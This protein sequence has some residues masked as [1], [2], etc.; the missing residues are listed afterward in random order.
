MRKFL[1]YFS[2]GTWILLAVAILLLWMLIWLVLPLR[3]PEIPAFQPAD[4]IVAVV[5]DI[6]TESESTELAIELARDRF[7][8]DDSGF[9]KRAGF[10]I[11]LSLALPRSVTVWVV[12][13]EH[14]SEPRYLAVVSLDRGGRIIRLLG[15]GVIKSQLIDSPRRTTRIAGTRVTYSTDVRDGMSPRAFAFTSDSLLVASDFAI[16]RDVLAPDVASAATQEYAAEIRELAPQSGEL[17]VVASNRSAE[18]TG[19]MDTVMTDYG[20]ALMTSADALVSMEISGELT[21]GNIVGHGE[22]IYSDPG[23]LGDGRSDVRFVYGALRRLLRPKGLDMDADIAV[24]SDRVTVDFAVP[25][26]AEYLRTGRESE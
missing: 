12:P 10:S 24:G 13:G 15:R 1:S 8:D 16:I 17:V 18:L 23:R 21:E 6:D 7:L 3:H 22:L 9:F 11:A 26:V 5:G 19:L 20:F 4:G 14:M 2:T 25:G